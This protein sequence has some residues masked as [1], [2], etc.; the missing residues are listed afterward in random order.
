MNVYSRFGGK[1]GVVEQLYIE[2]FSRLRSAMEAAVVSDQTADPVGA[3]DRSMADLHRSGAAYRRFALEHPTYYSLM[4]DATVEFEPS[5]AAQAH[6]SGT[7]GLLADRLELAMEAGH[8]GR[9]DPMTTAAAVWAACHGVMSL[10]R[11]QVGPP[12]LDWEQVYD[13]TTAALIAGLRTDR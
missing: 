11:R 2:G 13:M 1:D 4:F 5:T 3:D 12:G 9:S 10:E 7:L 8:I 6:A